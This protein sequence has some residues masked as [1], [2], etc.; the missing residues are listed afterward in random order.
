MDHSV[1]VKLARIALTP[2]V[3]QDT[4]DKVLAEAKRDRVSVTDFLRWHTLLV[5]ARGDASAEVVLLSEEE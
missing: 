1:A 4:M 5:A 2:S 3:A